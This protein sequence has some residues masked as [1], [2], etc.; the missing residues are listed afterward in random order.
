MKELVYCD[1]HNNN[2]INNNDDND[3]YRDDDCD[4]NSDDD[5]DCHV[6]NIEYDTCISITSQEQQ[7][8]LIDQL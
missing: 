4:Q 3:D 5:D 6:Y 8:Q 1:N 7:Q 2:N